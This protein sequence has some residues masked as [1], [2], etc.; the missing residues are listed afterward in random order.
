MSKT[1]TNQKKELTKK[2]DDMQVKAADTTFEV[3]FDERKMVKTLME[4]LN[5]G[6]TWKTNNAAVIVSLYDQLKKQNKELL[7][8]DSE[9]TIISLRGH[10][11]NALYQALLNVEGN[12][13]ESARKFITM[14]T[15]VGET[16]SNAMAKLAEM[17]TEISELHKQIAELETQINS[18]EE[19]E[20]EL[21]PV[22]DE[23]SK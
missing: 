1:L 11:L 16:V 7:N 20:A 2:V 6:Y 14:L 15:H 19:V 22:A 4:H 9:D 21:E 17:N 10:E 3:Q 13:I 5:K 8:S 18:A 12:G 23:A